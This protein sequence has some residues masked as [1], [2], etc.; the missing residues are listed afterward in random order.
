[1]RQKEVLWGASVAVREFG[2]QREGKVG[3]GNGL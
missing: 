1:M 3:E 2:H